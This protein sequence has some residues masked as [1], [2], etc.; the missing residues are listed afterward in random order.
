MGI[1]FQETQM[2]GEQIN[3]VIDMTKGDAVFDSLFKLF[4]EGK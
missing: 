2:T 3:D 4:H 1:F